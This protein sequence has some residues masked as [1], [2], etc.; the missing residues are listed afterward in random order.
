MGRG[1]R[2]GSEL[3]HRAPL[4]LGLSTPCALELPGLGP[5]GFR[6]NV[7]SLSPFGHIAEA[8]SKTTE[9]H[10]NFGIVLWVF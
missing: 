7:F 9:S 2:A 10:Q 5:W 4:A 6:G 3:G 1:A 8:F